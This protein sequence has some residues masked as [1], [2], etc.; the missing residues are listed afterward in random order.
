MKKSPVRFIPNKN[1]KDFHLWDADGN[2][3]GTG[4]DDQ[5]FTPSKAAEK[6]GNGL[7]T[8]I[9][10]APVFWIARQASSIKF[11][12]KDAN[13]EEKEIP[14]HPLLELLDQPNDYHTHLSLIHI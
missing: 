12:V 14:D 13:N 4:D 8:S 6:I 11:S 9:V 7:S 3:I 5:A 1:L 10:T 2:E